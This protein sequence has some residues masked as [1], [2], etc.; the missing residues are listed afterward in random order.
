MYT[1]RLSPYLTM[2]FGGIW[3]HIW[4]TGEACSGA[5]RS[6]TAERTTRRWGWFLHAYDIVSWMGR[7]GNG[8]GDGIR[9]YDTTGRRICE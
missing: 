3:S 7:D 6:L 9:G 1:L 5:W 8:R 4:R 2:L